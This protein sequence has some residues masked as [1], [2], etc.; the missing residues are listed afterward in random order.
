MVVITNLGPGHGCESPLAR[1]FQERTY[2]N[3]INNSVYEL[4]ILI[5]NDLA[6]K[7]VEFGT[8]TNPNSL[9]KHPSCVNYF[10]VF[11]SLPTSR[12]PALPSPLQT[13]DVYRY[14]ACAFHPE[15]VS[16]GYYDIF[17]ALIDL[18][19]YTQ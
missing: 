19:L 10:V 7:K 11:T 9:R 2:E 13:G 4:Q 3:H 14:F 16:Y 6:E 12:D 17:D 8:I 15:W 5:R 1:E 18:F